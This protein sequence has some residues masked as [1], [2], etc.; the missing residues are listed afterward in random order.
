[1]QT[2][3][4]SSLTRSKC[5]QFDRYQQTM[6]EISSDGGQDT[7]AIHSKKKNASKPQFWP[8]SLSQIGAKRIQQTVTEI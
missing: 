7:S 6:T 3:N 2:P 8:F 1:M 5:C 4:M